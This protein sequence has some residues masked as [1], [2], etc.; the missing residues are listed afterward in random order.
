VRRF[1]V[2]V[3]GGGV[4]AFGIVIGVVRSPLLQS[5]RGPWRVGMESLREL[6]APRELCGEIAGDG[7]ERRHFGRLWTMDD[8]G[9]SWRDDW[10]WDEEEWT[11]KGGRRGEGDDGEV[12]KN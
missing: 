9:R 1:D 6:L 7:G 10:V 8:G 4:M 5:P 3:Y 12:L 2:V 11:K